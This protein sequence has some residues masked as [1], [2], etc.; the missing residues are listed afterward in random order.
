M[1]T[2]TNNGVSSTSTNPPNAQESGHR[3]EKSPQ[4]YIADNK[5]TVTSLE[6]DST[7]RPVALSAESRLH[8]DVLALIFE[9]C[10]QE[11][12]YTL[13]RIARV[14]RRWRTTVLGLPK[15]WSRIPLDTNLPYPLLQLLVD[16]SHPFPI[17]ASCLGASAPVLLNLDGLPSRLHCAS[18]YD[19]ESSRPKVQF[20]QLEVLFIRLRSHICW[21][22]LEGTRFPRLRHIVYD[23][24]LQPPS[25]PNMKCIVMPLQTLSI[26]LDG[27]PQWEWIIDGCKDTLTTFRITTIWTFSSSSRDYL[28]PKLRTLEIVNRLGEMWPLKLETP[29][30]EVYTLY[31]DYEGGSSPRTDTATVKYL[32]TNQNVP[33]CNYPGLQVLQLDGGID[34][35]VMPLLRELIESGSCPDLERVEHRWPRDGEDSDKVTDLLDALKSRRIQYCV[36]KRFSRQRDPWE[37]S[38]QCRPFPGLD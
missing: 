36:V 19:W 29:V 14:S 7:E 9:A 22:D 23:H 12:P 1:S 3:D 30:L 31:F 18:L 8:V 4:E 37:G 35:L 6:T 13:L 16:R 15:A 21:K 27:R 17:H 26:E 5:R 24:R 32:R 28:F 38:W 10:A 33:L 20:P 34:E 11:T 2:P 25:F